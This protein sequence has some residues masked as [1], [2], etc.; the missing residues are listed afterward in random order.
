MDTPHFP[1]VITEGN[2]LQPASLKFSPKL[3]VPH[4]FF[5]PYHIPPANVLGI[6]LPLSIVLPTN[7]NV[8]TKKKGTIVILA[9]TWIP[10][11]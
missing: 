3:P 7:W 2:L 8:S 11:A 10:R 4:L 1:G 6:L 5:S 9:P